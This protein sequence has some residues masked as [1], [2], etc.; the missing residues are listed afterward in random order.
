[1]TTR[2]QDSPYDL[3]HF[4]FSDGRLCGMPI[5]KD[6]L[7]FAHFRISSTRKTHV[8]DDLSGQITTLSGQMYTRA[9]VNQALSTVF[10]SLAANRIS[11]KRAAVLAYL[12][13]LMLQSH[14]GIKDE[15]I[16]G[17]G[18]DA[19]KKLM[20]NVFDKTSLDP[21]PQSLIATSD[22]KVPV[23]S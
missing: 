6:G 19:W 7:C 17:N 12:G 16:A 20:R 21:E 14:S 4:Q 9:D 22:S 10:L 23:A 13:G 18:E 5:A 3:C 8:E 2:R 15:Y 1:M 11:P